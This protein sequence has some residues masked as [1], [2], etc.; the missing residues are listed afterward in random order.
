MHSYFF[1]EEGRII[2]FFNLHAVIRSP[3]KGRKL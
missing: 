1:I 2:D 3:K